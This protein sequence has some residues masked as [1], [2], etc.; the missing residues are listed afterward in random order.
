MVVNPID[1]LRFC[2]I[3]NILSLGISEVVDLTIDRA[4]LIEK[5]VIAGFSRLFL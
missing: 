3:K 5:E 4:V 1:W 2:F